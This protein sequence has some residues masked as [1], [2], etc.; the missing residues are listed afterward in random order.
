[1]LPFIIRHTD[2]FSI[3]RN[4][5]DKIALKSL[6]LIAHVYSY[7]IMISDN[8]LLHGNSSQLYYIQEFN[9]VTDCNN[10]GLVHIQKLYRKLI[11]L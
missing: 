7:M 11:G 2:P 5:V 8:G 3:Y 10:V 1:M 4:V 6:T 9:I